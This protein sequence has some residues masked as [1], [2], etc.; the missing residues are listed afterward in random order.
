MPSNQTVTRKLAGLAAI[1]TIG[2]GAGLVWQHQFELKARE[3]TKGNSPTPGQANAQDLSSAFRHAA[4]GALPGIV[5][6]E[7][8]GKAAVRTDSG[9]DGDAGPFGDLFRNEPGL[10]D[11]FRFRAPA[12]MPHTQGHAS[13][14]IIDR[15]GVILTNNHV[16][17]DAEQVKVKLSDG[18]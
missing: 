10:R 4:H 7:T 8:R 6:I 13:G 17:A 18:R 1:L 3:D 14:F 16:V 9:R 15:S 2:L 11:F 5:S 12:P